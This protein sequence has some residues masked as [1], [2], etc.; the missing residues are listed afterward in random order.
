MRHFHL[1]RRS[2]T[3][4]ELLVVIAIIALLAGMLLPALNMAREKGKTAKCV[5]NLKQIGQANNAYADDHHGWLTPYTTSSS[6]SGPGDYWFGVKESSTWDITDSPLLG[7]YYGNSPGVMLCPGVQL[8][9]SVTTGESAESLAAIDGSGGYAYNAQWFGQY[10]GAASIKRNQTRKPSQT[11]VFADAARSGMGGTSYNP[12]RLT[13][14]LY[15]KTKPDGSVYA[16]STSGTTHFRHRGLGM[17][18]WADGHVTPELPGSIN[19]HASARV[20]LVG[21]VGAPGVDLYN[22]I[23]GADEIIE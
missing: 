5:G 7:P 12:V 19:T 23:R 8:V 14:F 20:S 16:Y 10:G 9:K 13:A 4:I 22:P 3:L 1:R 18:N 6:T 15:C 17:V 2:F 21:Y 11:V